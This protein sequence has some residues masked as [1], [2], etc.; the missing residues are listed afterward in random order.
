ME[1]VPCSH[2]A[3]LLGLE[4][5]SLFFDLFFLGFDF[6]MVFIE[7]Q[8]VSLIDLLNQSLELAWAHVI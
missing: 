6:D 8:D 3:V 1:Q 7:F 5:L 2:L 4:I